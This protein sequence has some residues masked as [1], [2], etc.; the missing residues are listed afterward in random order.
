MAV[1]KG[2][3]IVLDY[4][5]G[6]LAASATY[7]G[8]W[9]DLN[10]YPDMLRVTGAKFG[11]VSAG[12]TLELQ[13]QNVGWGSDAVSLPSAGGANVPALNST[14]AAKMP[15]FGASVTRYVRVVFVNGSTAQTALKLSLALLAS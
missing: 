13:G 7:T 4:N 12:E 6:A 14:S 8:P 3:R 11:V 5:V 2:K 1:Y 10:D 9:V 15:V